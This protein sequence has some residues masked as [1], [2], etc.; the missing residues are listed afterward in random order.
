NLRTAGAS[1]YYA[2]PV[3]GATQGPSEVV[4]VNLADVQPGTAR[5]ESVVTHELQHLCLAQ[6]DPNEAAWISEGASQLVEVLAGYEAPKAA[7]AAFAARPD[8][9]LNAWSTAPGDQYRHYGAA[10]LALEY[11]YERYGLP[12]LTSLL[13]SPEDGTSALAQALLQLDGTALHTF[14]D[15]WSIGNLLDDPTLDAGRYGYRGIDLSLAPR[16]QVSS[17]PAAVTLGMVPY[18]AQY[19]E[20]LPIPDEAT[21]LTLRVIG[22]RE[23]RLFAAEAP[24]G[25]PVWWS[26]RADSGHSWLQRELDLSD[27][28]QAELSFRLW[29]D[30]ETGWDWA[31]VRVSPDGGES[32]SWIEGPHM[33]HSAAGSGAP[34]IVY[35]GRSGATEPDAEPRW[36]AETLDL[37]PY[38]GQAVTLR[39]DMFT[40]EAQTGPGL[41][42][43]DLAVHAIGWKDTPGD[44]G[45]TAAGFVRTD[46][47]VPV[48]WSAQ[49]V[50]YRGSVAQVERIPLEAGQGSWTLKGLGRE[51]D[52]AVVV[53]S[54]LTDPR[55]PL[56]TE[57]MPVRLT[58]E[59]AP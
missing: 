50:T 24:E 22:P 27:T 43:D 26:N 32:W 41:C 11:L 12:G 31:G 47:V 6:N 33:V 13:A 3:I 59:P 14:Y 48:T 18:A 7:V 8:V 23:T 40:D 5:Y 9:Q 49:L 21:D 35:T 46:G 57:P 1:G 53:V 56:S 2:V 55:G 37:T 44:G 10:F 38:A 42:L 30:I 45:W 34:P 4:S 39:I 15:D 51:V 36:V 54:A 52:R 58:I 20:L 17:Y 25:H 16:R 19:V 28:E 29:Y